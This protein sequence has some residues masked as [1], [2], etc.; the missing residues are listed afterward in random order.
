MFAQAVP[1]VLSAI[2]EHNMFCESIKHLPGEERSRLINQRAESN[3]R[4]CKIHQESESNT[5]A[6][7]PGALALAFI[8]GI[9]LG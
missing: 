8:L 5:N 7:G 3:E 4:M 9:S 6:L 2:K 1:A